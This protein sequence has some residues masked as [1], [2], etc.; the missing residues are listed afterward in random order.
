MRIVSKLSLIIDQI[1][2]CERGVPNFNAL[3]HF[4]MVWPCTLFWLYALHCYTRYSSGQLCRSK[5]INIAIND[6]ALKTG[7]FGLHFCC[8]KYRCIFNHFYVNR[9]EIYQIWW[10]YAAVRAI[11]LFRSFKV[12]DFGTNGKLICD[13]LLVINT[14]LPPIP[15]RFRDIAFS[16]SE[17]AIFAYPSCV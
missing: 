16:R 3:A 5:T 10:N 17:I 13:F 15:H 8:R 2:G 7:F 11:M 14:N 1:F 4:M 12:T 6:I 9:T